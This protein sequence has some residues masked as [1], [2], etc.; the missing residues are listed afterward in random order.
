MFKH[1]NFIGEGEFLNTSSVDGGREISGGLS[2]FSSVL[3]G[4][5]VD[6]GEEV[7][8]FLQKAIKL[9]SKSCSV[10]NFSHKLVQL[11]FQTEELY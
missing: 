3:G 1:N 7:D 2:S 9:K 11:I 8:N 4:D 5:V 6:T 10:G